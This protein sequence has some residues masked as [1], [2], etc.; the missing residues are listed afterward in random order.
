VQYLADEITGDPQY[1]YECERTRVHSGA[2]PCH[3]MGQGPNDPREHDKGAEL[4]W[5]GVQHRV[6]NLGHDSYPH[7][8]PAVTV[9]ITS[10]PHDKITRREVQMLY[11]AWMQA[12]MRCSV[13]GCEPW[14]ALAPKALP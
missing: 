13:K 2:E 7:L 4:R 9:P 12:G 1:S 3:W 8:L 6:Q 11:I 5:E 10:L 14:A